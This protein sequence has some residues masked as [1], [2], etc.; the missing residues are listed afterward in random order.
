MDCPKETRHKLNGILRKNAELIAEFI[1]LFPEVE[2][3]VPDNLPKPERTAAASYQDMIS[4]F[5]GMVEL[6]GE[7]LIEEVRHE[8]DEH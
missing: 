7:L 5:F 4:G 2:D 3:V 6:S 1:T 8:Q